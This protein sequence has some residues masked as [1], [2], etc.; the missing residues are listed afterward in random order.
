MASTSFRRFVRAPRDRVYRTI[1]DPRVIASW[2][3]PVGLKSQVHA[4]D[5]RVGGYFRIS[6][7]YPVPD[8]D[9]SGVAQQVDTFHGRFVE[10]VPD[11]KMV[12]KLEFE[13]SRA[14]LQGEMT[15]TIE[16]KDAPGGTEIEVYH[17]DLPPGVPIADNVAGWEVSLERLA[18]LVEKKS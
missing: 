15:I 18:E 8:D 12:M 10:L 3:V 16:L 1:L 11:E 6:L 13:T 14:E 2:V 4:F 7:T 5:S 17:D 9:R